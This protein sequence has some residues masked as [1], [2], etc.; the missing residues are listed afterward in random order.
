MDRKFD[1]DYSDQFRI[2]NAK[3]STNR[4]WLLSVLEGPVD[5]CGYVGNWATFH[6]SKW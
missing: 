5:E 1:V 3:G 4:K 2:G 6:S